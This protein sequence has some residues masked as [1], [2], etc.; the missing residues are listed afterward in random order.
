MLNGHFSSEKLKAVMNVG[1]VRSEARRRVLLTVLKSPG[2]CFR[3]I[4]R[5]TG[6]GIGGLRYNLDMLERCGLIVSERD[7]KY[8]RFFPMGLTNAERRVLCML[9][10]KNARSIISLILSNNAESKEL[11]SKLGLSR[12]TINWY[13]KKLCDAGV[14]KPT[15]LGD[16]VVY[17]VVNHE[18]CSRMLEFVE[19]SK[20]VKLL[21]RFIDS[22]EWKLGR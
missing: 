3:E 18:T 12:N 7:G 21:D 19:A 6:F 13:L 2:A 20:L 5:L 10:H 22:W 14:V 15:K 8:L 1:G 16:K 17:E 9:R 11:A 4:H